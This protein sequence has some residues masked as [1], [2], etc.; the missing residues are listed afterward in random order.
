MM[1]AKQVLSPESGA[2][3]RSKQQ[4]LENRISITPTMPG[5]KLM[6]V[7]DH[8][9]VISDYEP[10]GNAKIKR[11]SFCEDTVTLDLFAKIAMEQ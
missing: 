5:T 11:H 4:S 1:G 8:L 6:V 2:M 7:G 3:I 9:R 10:L